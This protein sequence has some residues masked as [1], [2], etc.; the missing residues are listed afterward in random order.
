[1]NLIADSPVV[2]E[3]IQDDYNDERLERE[4]NAIT[5][6]VERRQR[7]LDDYDRVIG[8]LGGGG[9]SQRTAATVVKTALLNK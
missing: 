9:A 6:D 7:M 8:M 5:V 4:F 3:L 1:M 2:S